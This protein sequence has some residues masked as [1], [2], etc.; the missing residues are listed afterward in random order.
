MEGSGK[1]KNPAASAASRAPSVQQ[2]PPSI[3]TSRAARILKVSTP[4]ITRLCEEGSLT[5]SRV[6]ERGWWRIELDSV[7]RFLAK[8]QADRVVHDANARGKAE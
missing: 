7:W 4:T 2:M 6:G 3:S 8:R 1:R 5:A